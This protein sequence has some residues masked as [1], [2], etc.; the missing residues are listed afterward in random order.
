MQ[1]LPFIGLFLLSVVFILY[2]LLGYPLL[3]AILARFS[4]R[5]V[6]KES[7]EKTVS[8]VLPVYNGE[9][10]LADKIRSILN[11]DYP[12]ELME[13]LVVSDGS[14]DGTESI[15]RSFYD[16]GVKLIALPRG[17]KAR[18]LNSALAQAKNDVIVLTDVRQPLDH[19]S[20]R[21]LIE[22]FAD[23]TIGV[24]SANL[25]I[26]Q[27]EKEE[28]ANIGLYRRYE[29]WIR[30]QL[31]SFRSVIGASGCYYAIRKDLVRPMPENTLLDDVY[32]PIC[33]IFS[34]YRCILEPKARCFDFPT[35]LDSEFH[36]KVRT[37]A[38][39]YQLIK[40]FPSLLLP[41]TAT[42][43]HFLSLKVGRLLLPFAFLTLFVSSFGLPSP[44]NVAAL[45]MQAVFYS[46]A[47]LDLVV[48]QTAL[49][50]KL[51]SPFRSFV[52]LITSA[53]CAVAIMF[54][55]AQAL[56]KKTAVNKVKP[57]S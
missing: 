38:G 31:S 9:A 2:V 27:G 52:V 19:R 43:F 45:L 57:A 51:T 40:F 1:E 48:P 56:W 23:P 6:K 10:F 36:R 44:W 29:A 13:I 39:V 55:P 14:D 12:K 28:E 49:L 5:A 24:V 46:I 26:R 18:A 34:G 54:V 30:E 11:L 4:R 7:I 53:L 47:A 8:V 15:A 33:A 41:W 22:C 16:H 17:G 3:V 20:L 35:A 42:G 37:Q 21:R 32:L 25:F 50:K